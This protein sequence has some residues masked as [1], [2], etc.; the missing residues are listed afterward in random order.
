MVDVSREPLPMATGR[1]VAGAAAYLLLTVA[2]G[3][4]LSFAGM[5]AAEAT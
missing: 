5:A 2:I 3:L 4:G 1:R